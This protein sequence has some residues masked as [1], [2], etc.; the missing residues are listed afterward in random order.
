M[1][2]ARKLSAVIAALVACAIL[3]PTAQASWSVAPGTVPGNTSGTL[4]VTCTSASS[5]L[6]VGFQAG[7]STN[8]LASLWNGSSFSAALTTASVT[9]QL[10][11]TTCGSAL[12]FAVGTDYASGAVPHAESWDGTTWTTT[13]TPNPSGSTFAALA[14]VACPGTTCFAAGYYETSTAVHPLIQYFN[15]TSW[16][17]QSL[18]LPANTN[19]AK[20]LDISCTSASACTAVGFFEAAGAPRRTLVETWNGTAWTP[21]TSANPSGAGLALLDGVECASASLCTAVGQYIDSSSVQ[22]SLAEGWNGTTWSLQSVPDPSGGSAPDL[23]DV[24]CVTSPSYACSAVGEYTA[25]SHTLPLAADWNGS[26][27]SLSSVPMPTGVSDQSLYGIACPSTC[28]A[29]GVS[30]YDGTAGITGQRPIVVLG[31]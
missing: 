29:D 28:M 20:L 19:D 13:S 17:T 2:T 7:T 16:S 9:S 30:L 14:G 6:V 3:A 10:Y 26:T 8:A 31:P 18:T 24:S 23:E 21:Q 5:C 11:D 22:H 12:C 15:G 27:W 4:G 25:S 1:L